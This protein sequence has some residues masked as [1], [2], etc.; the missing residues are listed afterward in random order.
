MA[1]GMG[2]GRTGAIL[3][4]LSSP[5]LAARTLAELEKRAVKVYGSVNYHVELAEAGFE[6]SPVADGE[7]L[8]EASKLIEALL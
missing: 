4:K 6:G 2:I 1:R 3:N 5:E 7:S 8:A